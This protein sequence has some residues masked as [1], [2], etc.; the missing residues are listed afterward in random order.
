VFVII[1]LLI[2][3]DSNLTDLPENALKATSPLSTAEEIV[4]PDNNNDPTCT[5]FTLTES[6]PC[7]PYRYM[8]DHVFGA[9]PKSYRLLIPG[10]RLCVKSGTT[11][12]VSKGVSPIINLPATA[13]FPSTSMFWVTLRLPVIIELDKISTRPVP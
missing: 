1:E 9:D 12:T 11:D 5:F 6:T 13:T 8:C 2:S 4:F 3:N 7:N 10:I